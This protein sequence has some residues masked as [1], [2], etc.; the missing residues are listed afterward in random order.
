VGERWRFWELGFWLWLQLW[1][2][3]GQS[4]DGLEQLGLWLT[5][6]KHG[7]RIDQSSLRKSKA[8]YWISM[9]NLYSVPLRRIPLVTPALYPALLAKYMTPSKLPGP[10]QSP[11]PIHKSMRD[12]GSH[13]P[14]KYIAKDPTA[15]LVHGLPRESCVWAPSPLCLDFVVPKRN[16]GAGTSVHLWRLQPVFGGLALVLS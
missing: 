1:C 7:V 13:T 2:W 16:R 8:Q 14:L 10:A 5:P 11:L 12:L 4:A 3:L 6:R 15:S 9:C